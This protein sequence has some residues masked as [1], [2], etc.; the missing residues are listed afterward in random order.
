MEIPRKAR[1]H[2]L[3]RSAVARRTNTLS[4]DFLQID[5]EIGLTF[6]GIALGARDSETKNR[7]AQ[8]ARRA[9]DTIARLRANV[10]LSQ[11]EVDK[12]DVNVQRLKNELQHLG[13]RF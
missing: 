12:L 4:V 1:R 10:E 6:S 3:V 8:S 9:F 2:R 13:Q 11:A 5:S 7:L